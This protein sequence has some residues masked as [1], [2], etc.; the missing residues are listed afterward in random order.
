[1]IDA[2]RLAWLTDIH[3]NFIWDRGHGTYRQEH[4]ELVAEVLAT[5]PEVVLL[6]GDIAEAPDLL[7]H[8]EQLAEAFG[9]IPVLFVLGNHDFYHGSIQRVRERV[10]EFCGGRRNLL[11]LSAAD[12]PLSFSNRVAVVGHDGWA[13]GRFGNLE[14][15]SALLT[16]YVLI[17]E[18]VAAGELGRRRILHELADEAASHLRRLLV[19]AVDS[20]PEV[21][22][23]THV[24]PWL[25]AS[26]H[27]GVISN[28]D[29]SPH[30]ASKA[31]GEAIVDVMKDNPH[32]R[33]TVLCGHTHSPA[34]HHPLPNVVCFAGQ[35]E[36]GRPRL[37]RTF[38]L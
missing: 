3:L 18:L 20:F 13:D 11:Y 22:L 21:V 35:A 6:S 37:Q 29:Y 28:D 17:E 7:W 25:E 19:Q 38:E 9:R 34:E 16:D 30:F 10:T 12:A 36:Y 5:N 31:I 33:L 32:R 4:A 27:L 26:C 15:S 23:V 24:P 1:M 8:L 14:G 2:I